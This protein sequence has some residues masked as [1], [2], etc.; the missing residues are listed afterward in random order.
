[1][2]IKLVTISEF[3]EEYSNLKD[4]VFDIKNVS[5]AYNGKT[6]CMC[7]CLGNYKTA[8][9]EH[10]SSTVEISK[11]AVSRRFNTV[12]NSDETMIGID[13]ETNNVVYAFLQTDNKRNTTL[14]YE[15]K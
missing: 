13:N 11:I 2:G 4:Y 10:V 7:G 12:I 1:M 8:K 15:T 5:R 3:V 6:G 14:F 9:E